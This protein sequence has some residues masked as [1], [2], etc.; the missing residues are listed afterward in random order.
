[1]HFH[2]G[3]ARY[4]VLRAL[5][6]HISF[7]FVVLTTIVLFWIVLLLIAYMLGL[8]LYYHLKQTYRARRRK[9]YDPAIE[10]VLLEEPFEK[11][12]EALRPKRW[13]D[14]EIVQEVMLDSMDQLIGSPFE[15][16]Q[17]A[18][19][20]LGI[21]ERNLKMLKSKVKLRRGK[22]MEA[23]GIMRIFPAVVPILQI[24]PKQT[25]DMKLVA[26]RALARI[27]DPKTLPY[28]VRTASALPPA[29]LPRLASLMLEFGAPALPAIKTLVSQNSKAFPPRVLQ[30]LLAETAIAQETR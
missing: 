23:L 3:S 13:G 6:G 17:R 29:M 1:M 16:L 7:Q 12:L 14:A 21:V 11:I 30:L 24:L 4:L 9:L 25:K 5:E 10:M 26:L 22:A 18:A 19:F 2:R 28:F 27:G 20:E 8:R 15:T